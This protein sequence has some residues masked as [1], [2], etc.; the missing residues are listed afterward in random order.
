LNTDHYR[1]LALKSYDNARAFIKDAEILVD[2]GTPGH[3]CSLAI[4]GFEEMAKALVC[5]FVALGIIERDDKIVEDVFKSHKVK[6]REAF[7]LVFLSIFNIWWEETKQQEKKRINID[8]DFLPTAFIKMGVEEFNIQ[9][10]NRKEYAKLEKI[11]DDL[12]RKIASNFI[13]ELKND[14][15]PLATVLVDLIDISAGLTK[16][17]SFLDELKQKGFYVDRES[18]SPFDIT[19]QE[20]TEYIEGIGGI[21]NFYDSYLAK[22]NDKETVD[23]IRD[24]FTK[25]KAETRD[26]FRN[27]FETVNHINSNESN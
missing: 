8:K 4:L 23:R 26:L 3:A 27:V 13:T 2:K 14:P 16:R 12:S 25:S 24:V 22:L 18:T 19:Q 10:T 11:I 5:F 6:H 9:V 1:N 20:A 7:G 21:I 17:K 15:H